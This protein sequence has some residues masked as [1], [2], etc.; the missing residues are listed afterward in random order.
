MPISLTC[1]QLHWI[2]S[3]EWA[4]LFSLTTEYSILISLTCLQLHWIF[5]VK[6]AH[7]FS[8]ITEYS[9]LISL[10]CPQ[11]YWILSMEWAY[12]ISPLIEYSIPIQRIQLIH[13]LNIGSE[14]QWKGS[15]LLSVPLYNTNTIIHA[16]RLTIHW[17]WWHQ[18]A[19]L[20]VG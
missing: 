16:Y 19:I 12:L 11:L 4:H 9:I 13:C 18:K 2:L 1:P 17:I 15:G 20:G 5:S 8:L 7:L 14:C 3:V 6:W 10:T